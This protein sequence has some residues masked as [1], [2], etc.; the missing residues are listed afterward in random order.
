MPYDV[1]MPQLGLTMTEGS[2]TSW[3]KKPGDPVQKGEMLF[4]VETDKVEMEVEAIHSGY[5][6]EILVLPGK[7]VPVGTV[8][9]SL[10]ESAA[11]DSAAPRHAPA[12]LPSTG[13][14]NSAPAVNPAPL[15]SVT[16]A[17]QP[18]QQGAPGLNR[19][20]V[21]PRARSLAA[22]LG[23]SL[24]EVTPDGQG[25]ICE[26]DILRYHGRSHSPRGQRALRGAI[27]KQD[28]HRG[29]G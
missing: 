10:S 8:I 14:G 3:L 15:P 26:A 22:R 19:V 11:T 1:V 7:V 18:P 25:R 16:A 17:E 20:S 21:S 24:S 6:D 5:L 23:V 13:P 12:A 2:V 28:N 29:N 9:A 4:T 27:R